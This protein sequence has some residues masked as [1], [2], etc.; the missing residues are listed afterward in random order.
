M[1]NA[2]SSLSLSFPSSSTSLLLH[3]GVTLSILH[4]F[5][6]RSLGPRNYLLRCLT[7]VTTIC[8]TY[9]PSCRLLLHS[10]AGYILSMV[11][12]SRRSFIRSRSSAKLLIP[13]LAGW[14]A[15]G[16]DHYWASLKI[17]RN[18]LLAEGGINNWARF[19]HA[20]LPAGFSAVPLN[21]S[22][23][24]GRRRWG[25]DINNKIIRKN[26]DP[27]PASIWQR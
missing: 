27:P 8:P 20:L 25:Q 5:V 11:Y 10:N 9:P 13:M 7:Y 23:W 4:K 21:C 14:L 24:R 6:W 3:L 17:H 16:G 19:E 15:G 12:R 2:G 26:Y 1:L 22:L 18:K